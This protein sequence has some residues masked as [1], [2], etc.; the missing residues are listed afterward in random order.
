MHVSVI[1]L[2]GWFAKRIFINSW[3]SRLRNALCRQVPAALMDRCFDG[4]GFQS[5]WQIILGLY[6]GRHGGSSMDA[7]VVLDFKVVSGR[8]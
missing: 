3:P 6:V 2:P 1:F 8:C 7:M 4:A 5:G